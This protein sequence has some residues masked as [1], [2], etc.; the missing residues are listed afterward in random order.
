MRVLVTGGAGY[1]GSHCALMLKERGHDVWVLDNLSNGHA[2][3]LDSF[4]PADRLV[5]ADLGDTHRVEHALMAN[6]IQ[7]VLHF[8]AFALV[9]GWLGL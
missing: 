9:G 7:A 4:L 6:R 2:K 5:V 8:A 3:A 1:I